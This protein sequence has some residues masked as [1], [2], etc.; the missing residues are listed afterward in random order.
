MKDMKTMTD[1][2]ILRGLVAER[3]ST[4]NLYTPFRNRLNR[5]YHALDDRIEATIMAERS[6]TS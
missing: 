5:I 2:Q 6:K 3:M 4:L 1:D